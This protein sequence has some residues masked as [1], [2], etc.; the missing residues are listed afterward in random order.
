LLLSPVVE[1]PEPDIVYNYGVLLKL[2]LEQSL[3][4]DL[5]RIE[6]HKANFLSKIV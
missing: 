5:G 3:F 6:K 4:P 1:E 2:F